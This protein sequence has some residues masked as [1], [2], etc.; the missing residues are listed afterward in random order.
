MIVAVIDSFQVRGGGIPAPSRPF[1]TIPGR[2]NP[3]TS[4]PRAPIPPSRPE[5]APKSSGDL[6][7][8]IPS[9]RRFPGI[10]WRADFPGQS[11]LISPDEPLALASPLVVPGCSRQE[12][13]PREPKNSR[14]GASGMPGAPLERR[15]LL[16]GCG[17]GAGCA[18]NPWP[19]SIPGNPALPG[20][21]MLR[22]RV[23]LGVGGRGRGRAEPGYPEIQ[24]VRCFPERFLPLPSLLPSLLGLPG[25]L[26]VLPRGIQRVLW[27]PEGPGGSRGG[28]QRVPG[29][30]EGP[31]GSRG[32]WDPEGG[33]SRGSRG[34]QRRVESRGSR[35]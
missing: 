24:R 7:R 6:Q 11:V 35:T 32:G 4:P 1:C 5:R 21:G 27:D 30:P 34:M 33:G 23:F 31:V 16:R 22:Q 25:I 19:R 18:D 12:F 15:R 8:S 3:K 28:I 20:P 2:F 17:S 26:R 13:L 9:R 10:S 29:D 14:G